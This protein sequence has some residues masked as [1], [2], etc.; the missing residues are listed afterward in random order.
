MSQPSWPSILPLYPW[1]SGTVIG[2]STLP[3]S[4]LPICPFCLQNSCAREGW[5][6][7]LSGHKITMCKGGW[8]CDMHPGDTFPHP[9]FL[10]DIQGRPWVFLYCDCSVNLL[11]SL[12]SSLPLAPFI[13]SPSALFPVFIL[14]SSHLG[15]KKSLLKDK[16]ASL[17][18]PNWLLFEIHGSGQ[19]LFSKIE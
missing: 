14:P 11:P 7:H 1:A 5:R 6:T 12:F 13:L 17:L 18:S 9:Q 3:R 8:G 15:L 4:F 19:P 10:F 2:S 16:I